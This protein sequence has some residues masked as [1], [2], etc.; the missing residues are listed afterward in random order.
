MSL[1]V[2]HEYRDFIL[3][4]VGADQISLL[5]TCCLELMVFRAA[6]RYDMTTRS[7]ILRNGMHINRRTFHQPSN[8]DE[9]LAHSMAWFA[10]SL[11]RCAIDLPEIVLMMAILLTNSKNFLPLS[12]IYCLQKVFVDVS[13]QILEI[14]TVC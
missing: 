8:E 4:L 10:D 5:R 3:Q 12:R 7:V 2:L 14:G 9:V 11:A 13:G 6:L 1:F